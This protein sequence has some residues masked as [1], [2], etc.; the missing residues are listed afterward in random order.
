[1]AKKAKSKASKKAKKPEKAPETKSLL[2]RISLPSFGFGKKEEAKSESNQELDVNEIKS[3]EDDVRDL[4]NWV[5]VFEKEYD[6]PKEAT[7][8]LLN[9]LHSIAKKVGWL[10][11]K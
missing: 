5:A 11:C 6:I 8:E 9:K 7:E 4:I 1:M 2:S 3:V 10:R